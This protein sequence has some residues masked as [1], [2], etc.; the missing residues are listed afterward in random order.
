ML[1]R[2]IIVHSPKLKCTAGFQIK[3]DGTVELAFAFAKA[4][5][6]YKKR[7][8]FSIA[9]GKLASNNM[10]PG[11]CKA[12]YKYTGDKPLKDILPAVI[13]SIKTIEKK[14]KRNRRSCESIQARLLF[15]LENCLH[16]IQVQ[17]N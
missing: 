14:A 5:D 4:P 9:S 11:K 12:V 1:R 16:K 17:E 15:A 13:D 6:V 8:G 10:M 3:E 7:T 2:P